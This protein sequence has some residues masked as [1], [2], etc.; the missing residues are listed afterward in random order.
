M[1]LD[2]RARVAAD[3]ISKARTFANMSV[4]EILHS[5]LEAELNFVPLEEEVRAIDLLA[6]RIAGA[7]LDNAPGQLI[8]RAYTALDNAAN[9]I[10]QM[11][12]FSV[13][14]IAKNSRDPRNERNGILPSAQDRLRNAIDE[15]APLLGFLSSDALGEL[16]ARFDSTV[17]PF[18]ASAQQANRAAVERSDRA[19][20]Q[21]EEFE[22][23]V[24]SARTT[25]QKEAV[26]EQAVYF[27]RQAEEH[28]KSGR[29]WLFATAV[30]A[31]LVVILSAQ[32]YIAASS[33]EKLAVLQ[34]TQAVQLITAKLLLLSVL[35]AATAWCGKV[36]KAQ[37][38]N[39]V[40]NKHRENALRSFEAFVRSAADAETKAAVL[41]QATTAIFAPQHS[42]FATTESDPTLPTAEILRA[43]PA[44]G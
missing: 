15:I 5:E 4:A 38:H 41:V 44:K 42:G 3:L 27:Q 23:I 14:E 28:S 33:P 39:Y 16:R 6:A 21:L 34:T 36:Y 40:V 18:V 43:L 31:S 25:L 10:K 1:L 26:S 17:A 22:R 2:E 37:R 30:A 32:S 13:V 29:L 8:V 20:E 12:S 35:L 24:T 9:A 19:Q 11:R 7:Q